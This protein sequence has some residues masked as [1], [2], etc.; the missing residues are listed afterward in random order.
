MTWI[1]LLVWFV[2][3]TVLTAIGCCAVNLKDADAVT[4][5]AFT[6]MTW[7]AWVMIAILVSPAI[8]GIA[9]VALWR[10][11]CKSQT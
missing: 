1:A 10:K 6:A 2:V 7:P 3:A 9:L 11:V 8:L 5:V 4:F